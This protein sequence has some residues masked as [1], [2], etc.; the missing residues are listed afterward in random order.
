MGSV[1]GSTLKM[2]AITCERIYRCHCLK[3]HERK[4]ELRVFKKEIRRTQ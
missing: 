4:K 1:G 2:K 3:I